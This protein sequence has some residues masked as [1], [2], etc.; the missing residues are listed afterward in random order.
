MNENFSTDDFSSEYLA[1]QKRDEKA[2][3]VAWLM[4]QTG[5][6]S[7]APASDVMGG[8]PSESPAPPEL[9]FNIQQGIDSRADFDPLKGVREAQFGPGAEGKRAAAQSLA[10]IPAGIAR[11]IAETPRAVG[12]GLLAGVNETVQTVYDFADWARQA[13][14]DWLNNL[15]DYGL[16]V[17]FRDGQ[18]GYN[19]IP[20]VSI[21]SGNPGTENAPQLPNLSAPE[22][23]VGGIVSSISQFLG[24]FFAAGKVLN[25]V[26]PAGLAGKI[27]KAAVQGGIADFT[28]FDPL[29]E[30][31]SNLVQ[32]VPA[33]ANPVTEYLAAQ[34]DDGHLEGRLKNVLEGLGLGVATEGIV[35]A[36][37][38][39]LRTV[40]NIR[41]AKAAAEAGPE[42]AEAVFRGINEAAAPEPKPLSSLGDIDGPAV[43]IMP[44]AAATEARP[45]GVQ[46]SPTNPGPQRFVTDETRSLLEQRMVEAGRTAEQAA[47]DAD[48]AIRQ[49]TNL[50]RLTGAD[51]NA[52]L[53]EK[54]GFAREVADGTGVSYGQG[55][56]R[57]SKTDLADFLAEALDAPVDGA[58][59]FTHLQ[60]A[61]G[62]TVVEL[63]ADPAKHISGRHPDFTDWERI[64]EV[65]EKGGDS[66]IPLGKNTATGTETA[67]YHI[68]EG[69]EALV[70]IAAPE[71][72]G[73]GRK[74]KP[75]RTVVLTAFR[76]D[77]A[78]FQAW[79]ANKKRGIASPSVEP[80]PPSA[81]AVGQPA[82]ITGPQ[83]D[84]ISQN[85]NRI[86]QEVNELLAK[87]DTF[88]QPARQGDTNYQARAEGEGPPRG[89]LD[90]L[91]DQDAYRVVF[92]EAADASTAVHEFQHLFIEEAR[93]VLALPMEKIA[94]AQAFAAFKNGMKAAEDWAG[95]TGG[96]WTRE[97]HE[98]MATAFERYLAE[99]KAPTRELEGL[100]DRMKEWLLSTYRS[101]TDMGAD[102]P[103]DV[104]RFFDQQLVLDADSRTGGRGSASEGPAGPLAV[105]GPAGGQAEAADHFFINFA[106]IDAP[107]DVKDAM[108]FMADQ[109]RAELNAAR[110]GEKMTFKQIELN[111]D[112]E[113]AWKILAE[114]RI[115]EPLNAEQSLAA[116]NLWVDSGHKLSEAAQQVAAAPTAEN[117]F[118]FMKMVNIHRTIQNEVIAARTETARALASW[119]I[120]AGPKELQL[121][122][123]AEML[124]QI[125]GGQ[126]TVLELA[127]AVGKLTASGQVQGLEKLVEKSAWAIARGSVQEAWV[128]G[129]LSGP[130]THMVNMASNAF[131]ALQQVFE[132]GVAARIG[133]I[134][135][136]EAGV[137][138][139]EG[140]AYM[141]G[142]VGSIKDAFRLAGKAFKENQGGFWSGKIDLPP[143][144]AISAESWRLAKDGAFG[145]TVDTV[146]KVVRIPGRALMAED[147][148]F[149]TVGYRAE[150][151]AQAHR[152]ATRE[153][154][155]GKIGPDQ[156]SNRIAEIL[157]NPPDNLKVAAV[158]SA[159]YATF[160]DAPGKFAQGW[161][162]LCW[163]VPALRFITP[164]VKTP[165]RIF[166]YAVAQRSPMAPLFREFR[167]DVAAGGG[168]QQMALARVSTGTALML[169]AADMAFNGL[170]TGGGPSNPAERQTL[171]RAGWQP[172]SIKFGDRYFSY[173]RAD[174]T[175]M[176]LGIA[177][178]LAEVVNH[179]DHNDQEVDPE[180][181]AIYFAAS[182]AGNVMSRSYMSGLSEMMEALANPKGGAENFAKRF[183]GSFVPAIVGEAARFNDPYMLE[184][185]SMVET[186]KAR[187]PGLSA[188]L[189]ARR[190]LWGRPI[191][192]RSGLGAFYDAISPI[193][194]RR[195]NPEPIDQEMLRLECFVAAPANKVSFDGVTVDLKRFGDAFTRYAQL[196]GNEAKLP[197]F[198][199]KG[200]MDFLNDLVTGRAGLSSLYQMYSDGPEGGK[201]QFI[202]GTIN[203]YRTQA[204]KQLLNEY[205]ELRLYVEEKK[206]S[207]PGK[208]DLH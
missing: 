32:E 112:Q 184:T 144:P 177:A 94:D 120:T 61:F 57:T 100:F 3:A 69:D 14:P 90:V 205:L 79:L 181:A 117:Q 70:V 182:I 93:R 185:S 96:Q 151:R 111:A 129:L 41:A 6:G 155:A 75:T 189:P 76:D 143:T 131:V 83:S 10:E 164:F 154:A 8:Q 192:Y 199:T 191:S 19:L 53:T 40:K 80:T 4:K 92:A 130:K 156:V 165:A 128:M 163:E 85:I 176:T 35:K 178:D 97:A 67:V 188:D 146:G 22:T 2:A 121:R 46:G 108:Q 113:D 166:N 174:P 194:S 179:M 87:G 140:L 59:P 152:Q 81:K 161:L 118:A 30:R 16:Q 31:L 73:R 63:G 142:Q 29:E 139:G 62:D 55:M 72:G 34:E 77:D 187:I 203:H 17:D 49:H 145:K 162:K 159:N 138:V 193:A 170:I 115:G 95:V 126:K 160:T 88:E 44:G 173:R 56:Y 47:A 196:A 52:I 147:E 110:R 206:A 168:R 136:D 12:H 25:V 15:M 208:Y 198:E 200:A 133:R 116:R 132:R 82:P 39:G 24:G 197:Q 58:K 124:E 11:N 150:L 64:A 201:A 27:G 86:D 65:I 99:G 68:T 26:K 54:I 134:L 107:E 104:R 153:A 45:A 51:P 50:A 74:D 204:K 103:D 157:E 171:S 89:R 127:D 101:L 148:F 207:K 13:A 36:F 78:G 105:R 71:V 123:M 1:G 195:E 190:D 183:A 38:T 109:Y 21:Y 33:L 135:G 18:G 106:R 172:Y 149:K 169:A 180:D 202:Q 37:S 122:H 98:K 137:Q 60:N 66:K 175:G 84:A 158:D 20:D 23:T 119:R 167:E 48:V 5:G 91:P 43:E 7:P 141:S 42:A 9:D 114:R 28:V 125:P 186:M 102:I